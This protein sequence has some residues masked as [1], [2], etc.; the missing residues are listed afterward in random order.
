MKKEKKMSLRIDSIKNLSTSKELYTLYQRNYLDEILHGTIYE[1]ELC[2]PI[3]ERA[4]EQECF[5]GIIQSNNLVG[6]FEYKELGD[7]FFI[8][9]ILVDNNY[10]GRGFAAFLMN[11]CVSMARKKGLFKIGLHVDS[12][13]DIAISWYRNLGFEV[14]SLNYLSL[15]NADTIKNCEFKEYEVSYQYQYEGIGSATLNYDGT[16]FVVGIPSNKAIT[17]E[18]DKYRY[19]LSVVKD[20]FPDKDYIAKSK[21]PITLSVQTK[22]NWEV[23][24]LTK[25]I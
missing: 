3:I 10:R 1:T 9:N 4:L 6:F 14:D 13:N 20:C 12:R 17:L 18:V 25:K 24:F 11:Y 22:S 16:N 2:L 21:S 8:N 19:D 23:L 5:Y 7:Y 15:L